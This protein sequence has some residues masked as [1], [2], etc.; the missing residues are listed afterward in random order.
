[1]TVRAIYE[2]GVFKPSGPV[3]LPDRV[4]VDLEATIVSE[5]ASLPTAPQEE[6]SQAIREIL[7][8]RYRTGQTDT[9]ARH[10]EHQP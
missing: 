9:A 7:S 10:N 6:P 3:D 5:D 2:N 1:M 4:E 8:R